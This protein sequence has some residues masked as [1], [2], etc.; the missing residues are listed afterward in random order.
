MFWPAPP[1]DP[2]PVF[3]AFSEA[4][5]ALHESVKALREEVQQLQH[6]VSWHEAVTH[7]QKPKAD[8]NTAPEYDWGAVGFRNEH[9]HNEAHARLA[10]QAFMNSKRNGDLLARVEALE[11]GRANG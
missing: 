1:P 11:K 6:R 7:G 3:K 8:P 5:D 2:T 4:I 9:E 10:M